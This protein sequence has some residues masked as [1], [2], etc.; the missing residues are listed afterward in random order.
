MAWKI[1]LPRL[2]GTREAA[3]ALVESTP[4]ADGDDCVWLLSRALSTSTISFADELVSKL[5]DEGAREILIV[6][7][8]DRFQTQMLEA[9]SRHQPVKV[10]PA[11]DDDLAAV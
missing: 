1:T 8:P 7:G 6:A 11:T 4:K 10:R 9:A 3:D 2:V 5:K